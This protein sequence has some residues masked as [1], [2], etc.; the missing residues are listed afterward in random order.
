MKLHEVILAAKLGRER[1]AAQEDTCG[2]FA[3][4]LSDALLERGIACELRCVAFLFAHSSSPD[5]YHSVVE[6]DGRLHDSMGEFD[7]EIIRKRLKIHPKVGSRIEV[8]PDDR[9]G[10]YEEE[11]AEL[12]E[13]YLKALRK[14]LAASV[15]PTPSVGFAVT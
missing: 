12:H 2:T 9:A 5:W 11:L 1:K 4:A 13:F 15:A 10:C 7:H 14:A 8:R 3:V 6:V